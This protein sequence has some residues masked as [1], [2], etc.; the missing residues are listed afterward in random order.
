MCAFPSDQLWGI[1][2]RSD[3]QQTIGE[4]R[5]NDVDLV[6]D[7]RQGQRHCQ[8][9][10]YGHGLGLTAVI[11]RPW[12][13]RIRMTR[14]VVGIACHLLGLATIAKVR[15]RTTWG[16]AGVANAS[17]RDVCAALGHPKRRHRA[18]IPRTQGKDEDSEERYPRETVQIC[19]QGLEHTT[20]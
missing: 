6:V 18:Q 20:I 17:R 19:A 4:G 1:Q 8:N 14:R 3:N 2:Q 12:C 16:L 11:V 5:R 15:A 13:A 9:R 7:T 10:H